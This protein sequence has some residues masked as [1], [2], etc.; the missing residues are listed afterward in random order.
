[1]LISSTNALT[2]GYNSPRQIAARSFTSGQ[3]MYTVPAG[4]KFV[5][6]LYAENIGYLLSITP[7]GNSAVSIAVPSMSN[8]YLAV[9]PMQVTFVAGTILTNVSTNSYINLVGVETD[10]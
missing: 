7:T 10:A 9:S 5:G 3:V 4:K 8:S 6:L 2:T 1:M